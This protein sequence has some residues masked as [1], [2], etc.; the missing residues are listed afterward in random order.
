MHFSFILLLFRAIILKDLYV[1][2]ERSFNHAPPK[3]NEEVV[4]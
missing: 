4:E 3:P 2:V 1:E